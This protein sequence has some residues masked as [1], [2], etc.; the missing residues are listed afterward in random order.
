MNTGQEQKEFAI[1]KGQVS[2]AGTSM[3]DAK[4]KNKKK[5]RWGKCSLCYLHSVFSPQCYS[6]TYLSCFSFSDHCSLILLFFA[7]KIG[8][9][10][11][12]EKKNTHTHAP[13]RTGW[14]VL[15]LLGFSGVE[16]KG[17]CFPL[18]ESCLILFLV[19]STAQRPNLKLR[20]SC[21]SGTEGA[22]ISR[23][24]PNTECFT[25][26]LMEEVI[27]NSHSQWPTPPA[28]TTP[29]CKGTTPFPQP[30]SSLASIRRRE[31]QLPQQS[32]RNPL[33]S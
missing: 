19:H 26:K 22:E 30:P 15:Y 5:K 23:K 21:S 3:R 17:R 6:L 14:I 4:I 11:K 25:M 2:R 28:D 1:S 9:F 32:Q 10:F 27:L 33:L 31:T 24:I 29:T 20:F 8:N 12:G 7:S 18:S 13:L 16:K